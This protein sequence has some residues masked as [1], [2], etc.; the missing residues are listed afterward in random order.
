MQAN[1][2]QDETTK[3]N[4]SPTMFT[5]SKAINQIEIRRMTRKENICL[6]FK[7]RFL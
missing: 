6:V 7:I 5:L 1:P 3:I 4:I 2:I